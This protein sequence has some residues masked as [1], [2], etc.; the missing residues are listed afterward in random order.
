MRLDTELRSLTKAL[1]SALRVYCVRDEGKVEVVGSEKGQLIR[2][3]FDS[4]VRKG[5]DPESGMP[6]ALLAATD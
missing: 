5:P 6:K 1:G 3:L 2:G 4:T